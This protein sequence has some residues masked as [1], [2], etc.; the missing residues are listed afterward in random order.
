[1]IVQSLTRKPPKIEH[2]WAPYI[3]REASEPFTDVVRNCLESNPYLRWTVDEVAARLGVKL[4][5]PPPPLTPVKKEEALKP[6]APSAPEPVRADKPVEEVIAQP[7]IEDPPIDEPVFDDPVAKDTKQEPAARDVDRHTSFLPEEDEHQPPNRKWIYGGIAALVVVGALVGIG[8]Q[9]DSVPAVA[10][11]NPPAA[12]TAPAQPSPAPRPSPIPQA[13]SPQRSDPQRSERPASPSDHAKGASSRQM[14]RRADGW[15]VVVASY[16]SRTPAEK[17]A[18]DMARRWPKFNANIFEQKADRTYYLVV[19]G[20][21]LSEDQ[22]Q[23]LRKR[24]VASGLPRDTYVK[25]FL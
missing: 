3:L 7:V 15:S 22:A 6:P 25:R 1:L 2:D 21:N 11:S 17:R 4:V 16:R 5:S 19:I 12:Q 9:K 23:A 18:H 20:Q 14:G 24:A 8:R 10:P 13:T